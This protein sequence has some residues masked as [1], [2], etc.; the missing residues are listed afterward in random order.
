MR[1]VAQFHKKLNPLLDWHFSFQNV[2]EPLHTLSIPMQSITRSI[3]GY[4]CN[5]KLPVQISDERQPRQISQFSHHCSRFNPNLRKA[6]RLGE[7]DL[8]HRY[9][10]E[11]FARHQMRI[12]CV[13]K[14]EVK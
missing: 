10:G 12:P 5:S 8:G 3:N 4:A 13:L 1:W 7:N 11:I 9:E 6:I 2:L 14:L